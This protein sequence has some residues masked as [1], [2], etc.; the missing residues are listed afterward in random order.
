MNYLVRV[1]P[2]GRVGMLHGTL[3]LQTTGCRRSVWLR[4][5]CCWQYSGVCFDDVSLAEHSGQIADVRLSCL[6]HRES[7]LQMNK[8]TATFIYIILLNLTIC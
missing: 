1:W 7:N 8:I 5:S 4:S 3:A 6:I 2:R